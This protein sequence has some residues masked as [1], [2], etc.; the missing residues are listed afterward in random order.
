MINVAYNF[1]FAALVG[2][3]TFWLAR[4]AGLPTWGS[5]VA[6]VLALAVAWRSLTWQ[7]LGK[8]QTRFDLEHHVKSLLLV[9]ENGSSLDIRHSASPFWLQVFRESGEDSKAEI[10]ISLPREAWSTEHASEVEQVL[11]SHNRAFA[12]R[13][14]ELQHETSLIEIPVHVA[15]IWGEAVGAETA[16]VARLVLDSFGLGPSELFDVRLEGEPS[17]RVIKHLRSANA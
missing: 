1:V 10:L 6:V 2:I 13:P 16:H 4:K 8:K 17:S 3:P 14:D 15:D 5:V 12:S 7:P 9:R 11:D